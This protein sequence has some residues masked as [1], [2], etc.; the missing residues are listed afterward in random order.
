M[1]TNGNSE[2]KISDQDLGD[3]ADAEGEGVNLSDVK[4]FGCLPAKSPLPPANSDS[5]GENDESVNDADESKFSEEELS[6]YLD[7]GEF[8]AGSWQRRP[9]TPHPNDYTPDHIRLH[10]S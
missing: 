1:Q 10:G 2:R 5:E 9:Y 6:N 7:D 4:S 3:D 8:V